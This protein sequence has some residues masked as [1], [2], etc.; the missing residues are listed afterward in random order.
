MVSDSLL[1][2][3]VLGITPNAVTVRLRDG[4]IAV[5]KNALNAR[6]PPRSH[7]VIAEATDGT[8]AIVGRPR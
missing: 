7:V 1:T 6:C 5:V 8:L 2:G 3:R 4:S